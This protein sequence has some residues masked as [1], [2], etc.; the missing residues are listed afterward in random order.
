MLNQREVQLVSC[1]I[2]VDS[3]TTSTKVAAFASDGRVIA[4]AQA[5]YECYKPRPGW[6]EQEASEWWSSFTQACSAVTAE[7]SAQ[8]A[9]IEGIACTH[10]RF[11]VV[12]VDDTARPLRRAILWNDLRCEN[13]AE[14]A[15]KTIG[16]EEIFST[17]GYPPGQWTLYKALW[18]K[19]HEPAIYEAT[20]KLLLVHD[21]LV[22]RLTGSL[23]TSQSS[24]AM[25][26]ALDIRNPSKWAI[27]LTEKLGLRTDIWVEPILAAGE[28]AGTVTHKAAIETGLPV[29]LPVFAGAGDQPCGSLGAGVVNAGQLGVNGGTSCSNELICNDLPDLTRPDFF[30]EINPA[31]GYIVENDVP[32]GASAV[33][34]WYR[35][36]F[37]REI[38]TWDSIYGSL[39]ETPPGNRGFLIVPYLQGVYGPYWNQ[40]ARG[41]AIGLQ[42]DHTR[43]H[44]IRGLF[45]GV[46]YESRR[47]VA[48]MQ[49]ATGTTIDEIRMYGGSARSDHWNQLFADMQRT[50]VRVPIVTEA[51]ALGAAMCAAVGCGMHTS[52]ADAV[53]SMTAID[54]EFKPREEACD[55]YDRY[56]DKVYS[57]LYDRVADLVEKVSLIESESESESESEA[58]AAMPGG[59]DL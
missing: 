5:G 39:G 4:Q 18:L 58:S 23:S 28:S 24:A 10:Q 54:R 15:R 13:E 43:E 29:G 20:A 44:V 49:R 57:K 50:V 25:T 12:P 2:G 55:I 26:G 3:S 16:I 8:H 51:T 45:E 52:F 1:V 37:G 36:E 31:G 19:H 14:E 40:N 47:E 7:V 9:T 11:S 34:N 27:G 30:V 46:A 56:Y 41:V 38:D 42:A 17:T 32:S 33:A 48:L 22:L 35:R 21:L 59:A 53:A 6:V